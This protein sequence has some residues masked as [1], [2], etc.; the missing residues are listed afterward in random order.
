LLVSTQTYGEHQEAAAALLN[1]LLTTE[2]LPVD[3]GRVEHLLHCRESVLSALVQRLYGL[4]RSTVRRANAVPTD[5]DKLPLSQIQKY[6]PSLLD[7]IALE[8]PTLRADER[9]SPADVLGHASDDPTVELWRQAAIKL[10]AG[11]H[12]LDAAEERP[13]LI[14][15]GGGWHVMRDIAVTLE[16]LLVL[17]SRL[18]EVGLLS[19][20]Q[21]RAPTHELEER[22]MLAALCAR[23]AT[24]HATSDAPDFAK[25]E[26]P[27]ERVVVGPVQ[28]ITSSSQLAL[29]QRRLASY[30]RPTHANDGFY[31][32][33]PAI[34][35]TTARMVIA[36]QAFLTR[37]F[38]RAATKVEG[39][40]PI[41]AELA[42]RCA[43]L[44]G[45]Q[46]SMAYLIDAEAHPRK[47]HVTHQQG[48]LTTAVGRLQRDGAEL[49][50]SPAQ[51]LD[52]AN[53]TH[54]ATQNAA[55]ALRRELL[56]DTSNLRLADPTREVGP[57]RVPRGHPL[58]RSLTELV[59]VPPPSVPE[60]SHVSPLQRAALRATLEATPTSRRAPSPY[61][62][63][64]SGLTPPSP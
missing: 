3:R 27:T 29:A 18:D 4:G 1:Q 5:A 38:A 10:L 31:D 9:R 7:R 37:E 26:D 52:L 53:A 17:D 36:S 19:E 47:M 33:K 39:G 42:R 61:P 28:T 32:G 34:D 40:E 44:G 57:T 15:A 35:A 12:A 11:T 62:Q 63:P 46:A 43:L 49:R 41:G 60:A 50:M 22:R 30:L 55:K 6:L 24:W 45:I 21:R 56:R 13:W 14:D 48:E 8:V 25:A 20:H 23:L 16:A 58:E 51:L 64:R 2:E 59:N 54:E